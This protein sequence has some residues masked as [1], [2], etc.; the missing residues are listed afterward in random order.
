VLAALSAHYEADL[1]PK[2][3]WTLDKMPPDLL[4]RLLRGIVAFEVPVAR[5]EVKRKLSQNRS[6]ADRAGVIAA[7][8]QRSDEDSRAI[9]AKMAELE[10][11]GG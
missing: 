4:R 9:A 1:L 7:L 2:A 5:L 8:R 10:S 11:S 3:P 6:A